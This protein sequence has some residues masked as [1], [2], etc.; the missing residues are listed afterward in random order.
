MNEICH[1]FFVLYIQVNN[2]LHKHSEV[3]NL[4]SILWFTDLLESVLSNFS[5]MSYKS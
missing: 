1:D 2:K 5:R 3:N 4:K